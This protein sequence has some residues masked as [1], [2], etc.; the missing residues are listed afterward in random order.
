MDMTTKNSSE[1]TVF[2]NLQQSPEIDSKHPSLHYQLGTIYY[3]QG[4]TEKAISYFKRAITSDPQ[5]SQASYNLGA[6]FYS[7]GRV[8]E[9]ILYYQKA[10]DGNPNDV[11]CL[12][13]LGIAYKKNGQLIDAVTCYQK[14]I[15]IEPDDVDIH[16]NLGTVFKELE[17]FDD[18]LAEY[19]EVIAINPNYAQAYSHLAA[20]YLKMEMVENAIKCYQCLIELNHNVAAAKHILAALAGKSTKTAPQEYVKELFD[21]YAERF[22]QSLVDKLEYKT[23]TMLQEALQE[24]LQDNFQFNKALDLGCGTGLSGK[25]FR[26]FVDHLVGID[27]S[28]RMLRVAE[29]KNIYDQFY[30]GD[31]V[32]FLQ[33]TNE[34]FELILAVDVLVY[35]GD[36]EPFFKALNNCSEEG[37]YLVFSTEIW[38]GDDFI[39]QQSGRYAHSTSYIKSLTKRYRF[40]A[41]TQKNARIR[42]EKGEWIMGE[43][44]ILQKNA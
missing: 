25:A 9:A 15:T 41:L 3:D 28:S 38:N 13:N 11:D 42:K 43:F 10:L 24:H 30:V 14:A 40:R 12:F 5:N 16:Y 8:D 44:Y 4:D 26:P 23:P 1:Q 31:I 32:E 36:L 2:N 27:L 33:T 17:Q 21:D 35:L 22:D 7:R 37:T 20:L 18:A 34:K 19:Q 29:E 6:I 39:L